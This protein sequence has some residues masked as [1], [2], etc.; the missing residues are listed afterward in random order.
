MMFLT[1]KKG[2]DYLGLYDPLQVHVINYQI[3]KKI[4]IGI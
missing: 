1:P 3:V 4:A 2:I